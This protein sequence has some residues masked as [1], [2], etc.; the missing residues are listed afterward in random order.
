MDTGLE[1]L[2]RTCS[3]CATI[4]GMRHLEYNCLATVKTWQ[5]LFMYQSKNFFIIP[6]F[7]KVVELFFDIVK[8]KRNV[9]FGCFPTF[10]KVYFL[11]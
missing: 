4:E 6:R 10:E 3:E 2:M 8:P 7:R 5:R 1:L 11:T 9:S